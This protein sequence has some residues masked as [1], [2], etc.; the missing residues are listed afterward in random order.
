VIGGPDELRAEPGIGAVSGVFDDHNGCLRPDSLEFPYVRD[1]S[2]EVEAAVHQEAG[3]VRQSGRLPEQD[4]ILQPK[5]VL[6]L[7]GDDA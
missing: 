1:G 4:S 3:N 7:V 5:V 2:L 6:Y